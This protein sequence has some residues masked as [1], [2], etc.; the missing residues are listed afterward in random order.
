MNI[1]LVKIGEIIP[2]QKESSKMRTA[3]LAE[4]L[5]NRG[6]HVLWWTSAFDHFNKKW[7]F[8]KDTDCK[9]Y[10]GVKIK[11]LKGW[12]YKKNI[13]FSRWLDARLISRKF[14]RLAWLEKKPDIIVASTP[15]YDLAF[16][17]VDY[18]KQNNIPVVLDVRDQWPDIFFDHIPFFLKF[19]ARLALFWD[20]KIIRKAFHSADGI[21]AVNEDFLDWA[22]KKYAERQRSFL[23]KVFYL[24]YK[25]EQP[26]EEKKIPQWLNKIKDRF[27]VLYQ[28]TFNY[29]HD[30]TILIDCAKR[31]R[32]EQIIFV[33]AG[34]GEYWERIK[35][36]AEILPNVVLPG[37]LNQKELA[38]LLFHSNVG[39][40]P[41]PQKSYFLPN[42]AFAYF[43]AGLPIISAFDG[44][45]KKICEK[46]QVGFYYSPGDIGALTSHIKILFK[47][48]KRYSMMSKNALKL[49]EEKFEAE[50]VYQEFASY[51]EEMAKL[52]ARKK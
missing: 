27:I 45:L 2:F 38:T 47:D 5:I 23:D 19:P 22:L 34:K 48:R 16:E 10:N 41:T 20:F 39:V 6:H 4:A 36:A 43:S 17:A 24:G 3:M 51:L 1:W 46:H 49:F 7:H 25:R 50:K 31:L 12:G 8:N 14:R 40:C 52:G 37:W 13:S 42:K 9:L 18:A 28:G 33:L 29:Y 11:A 44:E 30:P 26:L 35:K 15:A 21:T 32:N